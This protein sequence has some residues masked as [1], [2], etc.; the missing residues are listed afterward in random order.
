MAIDA[1]SLCPG[2]TGKKI[3]FCCEDS[4]G[5]LQKIDQMLEGEQFLAA[6]KHVEDLLEK[7]P[8]KACLLSLKTMLLRATDQ[9]EAAKQSAAVFLEKHPENVMA[10]A[11]SAILASAENSR[12]A[13]EK[14]MAAMVVSGHSM[15]ARVYEAISAVAQ[16][17]LMDGHWFA[18]RSLLQLQAAIN[19]QD[20]RP[21]TSLMQAIRSPRIPL[22]LKHDP[23][24]APCPPDAPWKARFDEA[25]A[26]LDRGDWGA[27][28]QGLTALAAD[29]DDWPILWRNIA[30]LRGWKADVPGCIEALGKYSQCDIPQEEA[31]ETAAIGMLLSEDPLGDLCDVLILTWSLSDIEKLDLALTQDRSVVKVPFDPATIEEGSPPP[32]STYWLLDRPMP[33]NAEGLSAETIPL[34]IGQMMLFGKQ[35]DR[36]A[37]LEVLGVQADNVEA[38]KKFVTELAGDALAGEVEQDVMVQTSASMAMLSPMCRG[39]EDTTPEQIGKLTRDALGDAILKRWPETALG[40]LDGKTP[41]QA[42]ADETYRV[43][44]LGAILVLQSLSPQLETVLDFNKLRAELGLPELGPVDIAETPIMELP[45]IRLARVAAG[46]LSDEDLTRAYRIAMA[47]SATVALRKF[48]KEIV[49]RPS[50]AGKDELLQA[51]E[52]LVSIE[53][54]PHKALEILEAGRH[55]SDATG[56]SSAMWDLREIPLRVVAGETEKVIAIIQH[57]QTEHIREEGVADALRNLLIQMGVMQ[58]DGTPSPEMMAQQPGPPETEP[59]A[60]EGKLWTPGSDEPGGEKKLWTPD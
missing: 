21:K 5:E 28:E 19:P 35:T 22:L 13:L 25:V 15:S 47:F 34:L 50:F 57:I 32:K 60:E 30:T 37:R 3:K 52:M 8:D 36:E 53:E 23:P 7:T 39:P 38:T 33:E 40:I 41:R 45:P 24:V 55:E 18:A 48:A 46:G 14:L 31:V 1:Y 12:V 29:V 51:Y 2:G 11:E 43:K 16:S 49:G 44:L 54:D 4:V 9:H 56:K 6:L 27:V 10:L 42:A 26:P 58:P 17:L 59:P 20:P